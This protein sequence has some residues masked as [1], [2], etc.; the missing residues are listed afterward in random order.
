MKRAVNDLERVLKDAG[1]KHEIYRY[2]AAHAF[3]N[4]RSPAYDAAC[5]TKAW[6]RMMAFLGA[7]L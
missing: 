5:A 2:D 3:A 6:D 4:E 7:N 1:I